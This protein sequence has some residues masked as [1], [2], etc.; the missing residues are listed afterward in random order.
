MTIDDKL[1]KIN[2]LQAQINKLIPD[3]QKWNVDFMEKVKIDFTFASNKLEGNTV[4]YGQTIR[5]CSG[6]N[7]EFHG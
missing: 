1:K 2:S 5:K 4:T 7:V 3:Q 6:Y